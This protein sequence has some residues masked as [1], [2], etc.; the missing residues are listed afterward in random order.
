MMNA[1][2]NNEF[3]N[4]EFSIQHCCDAGDA[5]QIVLDRNLTPAGFFGKRFNVVVLAQAEFNNEQ[6]AGRKM[7]SNRAD[8][9]CKKGQS[10][11][12]RVER[13]GGFESDDLR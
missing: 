2:V 12:A 11:V 10:I 13:D 7:R 4:S 3:F 8:Q 1:E 5:L 6:P 9:L